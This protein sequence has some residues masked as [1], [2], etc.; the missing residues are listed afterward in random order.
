M[1]PITFRKAMIEAYL[2]G[3]ESVVESGII[4]SPS[5]KEARDW[6]DN[7]YG[8]TVTNEECDCCEDEDGDS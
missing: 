3:A 1:H 6:F 2:A 7:E 5:K 8:L 4:E